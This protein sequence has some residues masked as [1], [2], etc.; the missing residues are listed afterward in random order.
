MGPSPVGDPG[1]DATVVGRTVGGRVLL[2]RT[3]PETTIKSTTAWRRDVPAEFL[4]EIRRLLK[5]DSEMDLD[6]EASFRYFITDFAVCRWRPPVVP[7]RP[8]F[9]GERDDPR[10][11]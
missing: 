9:R 5:A 6:F 2:H 3:M 7:R 11:F 4:I 1:P 8:T 10:G